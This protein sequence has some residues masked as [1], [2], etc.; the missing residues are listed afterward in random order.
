M[1][2]NKTERK[3]QENKEKNRD[4]NKMSTV[5]YLQYGLRGVISRN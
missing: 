4:N 5:Y 2:A 1:G 3:K